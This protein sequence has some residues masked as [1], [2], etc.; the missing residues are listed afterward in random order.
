MKQSYNL[1]AKQLGLILIAISIILLLIFS[2]STYE[3][4]KAAD[5]VCREVCGPEMGPNCPHTQSIPLQSYVGF[6][7]AFILAGIGV[8]MVLGGRKYQEELTEKEKK[9]EKTISTLKGDE[10]KICETIKESG[11]AIFQSDLIEKAGFSKVKVS[12]ILDKLEGKGLI[13]RRRRGMTNLVLMK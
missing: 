11:G 4:V 10:R 12:R 3:L 2:S 9:L 13:E 6:S 5:I 1:S 8:F 7:T